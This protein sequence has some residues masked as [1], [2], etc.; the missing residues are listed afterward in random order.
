VQQILA[1]QWLDGTPQF[2]RNRISNQ[3]EQ[4]TS[5]IAEAEFLDDETVLDLLPNITPEMKDGI[6][7]RK[8]VQDG[9]RFKDT[10]ELEGLIRDILNERQ[11]A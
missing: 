9:E 5:I 8:A 3:Q 1:L 10:T 6:L 11:E 4:I 7:Q 2:K